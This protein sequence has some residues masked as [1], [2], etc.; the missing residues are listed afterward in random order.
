MA[1][2]QQEHVSNLQ[3]FIRFIDCLT[4]NPNDPY[5]FRGVNEDDYPLLPSLYRHPTIQTKDG[6]LE[7]ENDLIHR[8]KERSLPYLTAQ[9][10]TSW[11]DL[12][13]MQHYGIPTR[14]LD[15]TENPLIALFFALTSAKKDKTT[16]QYLKD[17]AVWA[18]SPRLWNVKSL[19]HISYNGGALSVADKKIQSYTPS[20]ERSIDPPALPVAIFGIHNSPRIVAQRGVFTIFGSTI[21]PIQDIYTAEP[22]DNQA[23]IKIIVNRDQIDNLSNKLYATGVTEAVVFPGLDGLAR[24]TKRLFGFKE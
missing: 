2:L 1:T 7:L 23:L 8:F 10:Y 24:E 13:L 3:E 11:E 19:S 14:L 9:Q 15:W 12:F 16:N 20:T 18:L 21:Q 6:L 4:N 5:W 17:A 22:F